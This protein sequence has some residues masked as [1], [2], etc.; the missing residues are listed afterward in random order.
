MARSASKWRWHPVDDPVVPT[1]PMIW[2]RDT[3]PDRTLYPD[4]WL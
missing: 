2:P 3:E 4:M 1:Y